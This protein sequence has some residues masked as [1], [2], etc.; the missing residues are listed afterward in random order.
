[1][2][3]YVYCAIAP[4]VLPVAC[5]LF[6][7]SYFVYKNQALYVY[8]QQAESGGGVSPNKES[9]SWVRYDRLPHLPL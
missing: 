2:V 5:L 4:I 7:G 9:F 1:M 6:T 3:V 8:V